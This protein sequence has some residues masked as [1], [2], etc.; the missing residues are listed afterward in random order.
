[1]PE[2]PSASGT[3]PATMID[4]ARAAGV[5][6]KTVSRVMNEETYVRAETRK[7]VVEAAHN[8]NYQFNQ[9]ARTLRAGSAHIVALLVNNPN[10]SYL[11][12]V[13]IGALKQ[14]HRLGMQLVLD[15]CED[16]IHGV[17]RI[18]DVIAPVGLIIAPPLCEDQ[19]IL[20]FLNDRK[21]PYVVIAPDAASDVP[22]SVSI[23]D[24][25]AA[26]EMTEHLLDIGHQRIA[27]IKGHPQH[28]AARKR[29]AGYCAALANANIEVDYSIIRQGYFDWASGLECAE[30]LL[31][32]P[33]RPTAVFACN[34]DMAASVMT[35]AYRRNIRIPTELSVVGFDDTE[36]ASIIS[37]QL[38]TVYQP[39]SQLAS[40][41]V[42]L[43]VDALSPM[44]QSDQA[45][46]LNHKIIKR[47]SVGEPFDT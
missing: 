12:N 18:L 11:A 15:Q 24:E 27:F 32:L 33:K 6:L 44:K 47:E 43:L 26:R 46:M 34:D 35:A 40:K 31:D 2:I 25:L 21:I 5:S 37:P 1:M 41:A 28:S 16:G 45:V 23:D 42:E 39:I 19:A 13:H 38:T 20:K 14:C 17:R 30:F 22:L 8:L 3:K 36:I 7:I 4:V 29:F 9:A 10:R